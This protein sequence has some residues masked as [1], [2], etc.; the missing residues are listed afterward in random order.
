V[1]ADIGVVDVTDTSGHVYHVSPI[2]FV[3]LGARV[4][5]ELVQMGRQRL[6]HI[7][8]GSCRSQRKSGY[9]GL[10]QEIILVGVDGTVAEMFGQR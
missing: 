9:A 4:A 10:W 8:Q 5:E 1:G 3:P 7:V 2:P 6:S